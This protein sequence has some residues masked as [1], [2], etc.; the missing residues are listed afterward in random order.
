MRSL[1]NLFAI[2]IVVFCCFTYS[3]AIRC[4]ICDN[5]ESCK[6]PAKL[7]CNATMANTARFYLDYHHT[8]VNTTLTSQYLDCFSERIE[9]Y[10][11]KFAFKGCMYNNINACELPL[12]Q[13]HAPGATKQSCNKCNNRDYCNPANRATTN[14]FAIAATVIMGIASRRIWA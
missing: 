5:E 11:G 2:T 10:E 12:R 3:F 7:E 4:L 1:K 9:S 6:K 13:M 14:V 8:G